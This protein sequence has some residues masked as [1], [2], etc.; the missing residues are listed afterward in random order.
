MFCKRFV[1]ICLFV[2]VLLW[3]L[4]VDNGHGRLV[5][6]AS[7]ELAITAHE[8]IFYR[9]EDKEIRIGKSGLYH[10]YSQI[11]FEHNPNTT[12]LHGRPLVFSHSVYRVMA[13]DRGGH[14]QI[15]YRSYDT[16]C[17]TKTDVLSSSYLGSVFQLQRG[18]SLY[19][20]VSNKE[21]VKPIPHMNIFGAYML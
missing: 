1:N 14:S 12:N 2:R 13:K 16:P 17:Q 3:C 10:V 18:D 21:H 20:K 7:H 4:F 9:G 15:L 6:N 11:L 19:V 8:D 5:W